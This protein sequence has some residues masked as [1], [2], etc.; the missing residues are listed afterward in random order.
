M[1]GEVFV[2]KNLDA[3]A[4]TENRA[5]LWQTC[6]RRGPRGVV[7]MGSEDSD[8]LCLSVITYEDQLDGGTLQIVIGRGGQWPF[9]SCF[10]S[11]RC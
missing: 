4:Q 7:D 6:G 5:D 1:V 10:P 8:G 9:L 2:Y 11:E 3:T